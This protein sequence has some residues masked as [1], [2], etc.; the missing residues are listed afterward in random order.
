[1]VVFGHLFCTW[2]SLLKLIVK[3]LIIVYYVMVSNE[4]NHKVADCGMNIHIVVNKLRICMLTVFYC[5]CKL[6][7]YE[8]S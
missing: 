6:V 4:C 8:Y 7:I 1:M 2:S 3:A 5:D